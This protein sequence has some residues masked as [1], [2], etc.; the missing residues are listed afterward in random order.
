M[1]GWWRRL[2]HDRKVLVLAILAGLPGVAVALG[3]LWLGGFAARVQWTALR[4]VFSGVVTNGK[5]KV[6]SKNEMLK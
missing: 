2:G 1:T 4:S 6:S 5:I 3:F